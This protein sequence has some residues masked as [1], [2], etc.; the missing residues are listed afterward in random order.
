[1]RRAHL[2]RELAAVLDR[3]DRDDLTGAG[4]ATRLN[5][6][7]ADRTGAEDHDV[8]AGLEMHVGMA[9]RRIPTPADRRAASAPPP[10]DR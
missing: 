2:E 10:A 4:D 5:R 3:I 9:R 1:M 8:G 7:E 6:A